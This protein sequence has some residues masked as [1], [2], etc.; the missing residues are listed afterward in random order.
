MNGPLKMYSTKQVVQHDFRVRLPE[1]MYKL[2]NIHA[3]RNG[4]VERGT[5]H[6]A[7]ST[8]KL[9]IFDQNY[10]NIPEMAALEVRQEE[11]LRQLDELKKQM[12]SIRNTL[13][14]ANHAPFPT[15]ILKPKQETPPSLPDIIINA[16]PTNPPYSLELIQKLWK[17]Y[18]F[19]SVKTY[20]HSSLTTLTENATELTKILEAFS[21][22]TNVPKVNVKLI[23][24]D[25]GA[26]V[27]LLI[28]HQPILGEVNILRYLSR[29]S[30]DLLNYETYNNTHEIDTLLDISYNIVKAKTKTERGALLKALSKSLGKSQ[31]LAGRSQVSVADLAAYSAIKQATSPSEVSVSLG[32]WLQRCAAC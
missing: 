7:T 23:W 30:S 31:W 15:V 25:V 10:Q 12:D 24:K 28:S 3:A 2:K 5:D 19:L 29:V 11:I 14:V 9:D 21:A 16:S 17:N 6:V 1:C 4:V 26:N 18:I 8:R 13:K 22:E 27:E 20:T 32:K